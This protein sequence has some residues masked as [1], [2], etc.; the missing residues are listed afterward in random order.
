MT[1]ERSSIAEIEAQIRADTIWLR[2]QF[3]RTVA[4]LTA[5]EVA[6]LAGISGKDAH[7]TIER[8]RTDGLIFSVTR[9]L[10]NLY[11]TFQFGED[12]RPLPIVGNVLCILRQVQ[13][14][15]DW[16]NAMWFFG[17]NGWLGGPSP[18]DVLTSEPKL[19]IKAA[20]QEVAEDIE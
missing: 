19:V 2:A 14:R 17:A 4:T 20:E 12:M 18:M 9:E 3:F 15:S 16:D 1:N 5:Q 6:T 8:W 13:S 11:P 10:G 7:M